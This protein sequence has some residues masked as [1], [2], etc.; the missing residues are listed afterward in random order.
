MVLKDVF[1]GKLF[2]MVSQVDEIVVYD[3][4]DNYI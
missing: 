1:I 4:I 3:C 2:F